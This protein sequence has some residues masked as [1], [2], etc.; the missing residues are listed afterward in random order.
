MNT[1]DIGLAQLAMHSSYETAG[2]ADVDYMIRA[3]GLLSDEYHF[4]RLTANISWA[5][6]AP[7]HAAARRLLSACAD[8]RHNANGQKY[9]RRNA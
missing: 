7:A 9:D 6:R 2:C 3:L 1:V 4:L 5:D 8:M